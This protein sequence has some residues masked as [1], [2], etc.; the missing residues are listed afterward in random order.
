[1]IH[2]YLLA[3]LPF[4]AEL[5]PNQDEHQCQH[6]DLCQTQG[7]DIDQDLNPDPYPDQDTAQERRK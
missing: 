6:T 1:M 3:V 7:P 4:W 2:V 5:D